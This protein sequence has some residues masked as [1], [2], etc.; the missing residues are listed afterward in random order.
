M[1]MEISMNWSRSFKDKK[2][3]NKWE[4]VSFILNKN[5]VCK[6]KTGVIGN[7]TGSHSGVE[8]IVKNPNGV[9]LDS[10]NTENSCISIKIDTNKLPIYCKKVSIFAYGINYNHVKEVKWMNFF[11]NSH[12]F[13][14]LKNLFSL[15]HTNGC[16]HICDLIRVDGCDF[17]FKKVGEPKYMN[18]IDLGKTFDINFIDFP[19]PPE[20]YDTSSGI[21]E[22]RSN[23]YEENW[24]R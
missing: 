19:E 6:N 4:L 18:L 15:A 14:R 16:L 8:H 2:N 1:I 13:F 24:G 22:K 9:F 23:I 21:F 11:F 3:L 17:I 20:R 7:G 5:N 12:R 10:L